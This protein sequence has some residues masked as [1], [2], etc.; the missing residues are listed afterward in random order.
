MNDIYLP[1][2]PDLPEVDFRF[3]CHRLRLSG[4]SFSSNPSAFYV[5]L[6]AAMM[7]YLGRTRSASIHVELQPDGFDLPSQHVLRNMLGM[8]ERASL[9]GNEV[10][11]IWQHAPEDL[12]SRDLGLDMLEECIALRGEVRAASPRA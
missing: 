1:A 5:P 8:L 4:H 6:N 7:S 12:L 2:D 3:S 10:R 11:V 9:F